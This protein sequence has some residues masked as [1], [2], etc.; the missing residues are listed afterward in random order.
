MFRKEA[1]EE[2][3]KNYD[4]CTDNIDAVYEQAKYEVAL[5]KFINK[6]ESIKIHLFILK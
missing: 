6:D 3:K 5:N 4:I 2:Y 1:M